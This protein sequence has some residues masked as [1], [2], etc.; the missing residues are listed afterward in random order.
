MIKYN[1]A[2]LSWRTATENNNKGFEVQRSTDGIAFNDLA[3][4]NGAGTSSL[5]H[6]YNYTDV[7]VVSGNNYY[8]LKQIDNDGRL[9]YFNIIKLDYSKFAWNILGNPVKDNAIV[10]LQL[11]KTANVAMK[12]ISVKGAC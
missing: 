10:E 4:V 2:V 1:D 3:F 5:M 6:S 12:I 8:R 9:T 7:K 11:D